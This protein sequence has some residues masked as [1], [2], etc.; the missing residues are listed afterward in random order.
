[1]FKFTYNYIFNILQLY[2][3][4][5]YAVENFINFYF[6]SKKSSVFSIQSYAILHS[7]NTSNA[8]ITKLSSGK[9]FYINKFSEAEAK[10]NK[11]QTVK[12]FN[13]I[14]LEEEEKTILLYLYEIG[15]YNSEDSNNYEV[16]NVIHKH[17]IINKDVD[18]WF[19]CI[20]SKLIHTTN[21]EPASSFLFNDI[22]NLNSQTGNILYNKKIFQILRDEELILQ[23]NLELIY[24]LFKSKKT[25]VS[26]PNETDDS[27]LAGKNSNS[28]IKKENN[29][30]EKQ[31]IQL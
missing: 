28:P 20:I 9:S 1:M 8:E 4:E 17:S 7:L 2:S 19:P 26:T 5:E 21:E 31:I 14:T 3:T 16:F 27:K 30:V 6:S 13:T 15:D 23:T 24:V 12:Y 29:N 11:I 10:N 18:L 25:Y 22:T